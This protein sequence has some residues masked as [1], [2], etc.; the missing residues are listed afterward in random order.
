M[1]TKNNGYMYASLQNRLLQIISQ[2]PY[3]L[4]IYTYKIIKRHFLANFIA[5]FFLQNNIRNNI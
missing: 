5:V 3:I 2:N 4:T 1:G